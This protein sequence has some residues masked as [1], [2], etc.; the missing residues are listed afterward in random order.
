MALIHLDTMMLSETSCWCP[1]SL[2]W[3]LPTIPR[4]ARFTSSTPCWAEAPPQAGLHCIWRAWYPGFSGHLQVNMSQSDVFILLLWPGRSQDLT[5]QMQSAGCVQS[6]LCS[7]SARSR[8]GYW[9]CV[10]KIR[11]VCVQGKF[12]MRWRDMVETYKDEYLRNAD[13]YNL[14]MR[15]V[16]HNMPC[17]A[18]VNFCDS[19]LNSAVL[20]YPGHSYRGD[21][22]VGRGE[23]LMSQGNLLSPHQH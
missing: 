15:W 20:R 9:W 19:G 23:A 12:M 5:R 8:W 1:P 11:T 2:W 10:M 18:S 16:W 4:L 21:L 13:D 14:T 17:L 7:G 3:P 22:K 6:K